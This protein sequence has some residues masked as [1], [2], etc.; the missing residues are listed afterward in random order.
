M[1]AILGLTQTGVGSVGGETPISMEE[2]VAQRG[3]N[4]DTFAIGPHIDTSIKM[5]P[6]T[7]YKLK[8]EAYNYVV[9]LNVDCLIKLTGGIAKINKNSFK[10]HHFHY[11]P[12]ERVLSAFLATRMLKL[13]IGPIAQLH[14]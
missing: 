1:R 10:G 4:S 7:T 8:F 9:K 12:R 3:S 14:S 11:L 6:N 2:E 13:I 5:E